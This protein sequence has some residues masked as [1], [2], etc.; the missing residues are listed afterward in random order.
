MSFLNKNNLGL[1]HN[2]LNE[3]NHNFIVLHRWRLGFRVTDY[4]IHF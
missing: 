1:F 3:T 2:T 4:I